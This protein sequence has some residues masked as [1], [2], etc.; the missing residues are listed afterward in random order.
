ME[1][2]SRV[3]M[4][5]AMKVHEVILWARA[6]KM[7]WLEA[8]AVLKIRPRTLRRWK[9]KMDRH[10]LQSLVDRRCRIPSL[11][12]VA[13]TTIDEILRLYRERYSGFNVRHFHEV[14]RRDHG[15]E[16]S[17]T[18][19]KR[20][21]QG[22]GLVRKQRARGTHRMRRERQACLGAM[23][24]LDGSR[25][26]WLASQPGQWQT[27]IC[28][29]D[30]ATGR[31]LHARLWPSES[32]LAVMSALAAVFREHGLPQRLY[33][34]R[35][36]W[37]AH[38]PRRG[39][40][41]DPQMRTQVQRALDELGIEHIRAYSPQ[42]R[43]RSER[44]NRTLQGRVVNELRVRGITTLEHANRF[45]MDYRRE[46]D[47]RFARPAADPASGFVALGAVDLDHYLC[48][49]ATR[50]VRPDNTVVLG[51]RLLQIP[52]QAGRRSCQGMRV[53]VRVH[54]AGHITVDAGPRRLAEYDGAGS[55]RRRECPVVHAHDRRSRAIL[56]SRSRRVRPRK[57]AAPAKRPDHLSKSSGHITC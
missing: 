8:A 34:D 19:V 21:L 24:H 33:T 39:G 10:G 9:W 27:M 20:V 44:A 56:R 37:A 3:A 29:V 50:T 6:K 40:K 25:H 30:D 45:L 51:K 49:R 48:V 55:L 53:V 36:S 18:F 31:L 7:T 54:L 14:V 42:A 4:E 52:K 38:T 13:G 15:V 23:L 1:A 28:V 17:Y 12:R 5:R 43:G 11:R 35:A 26:Q 16:Q 46:Y 57:P 2:Y 32:R 47:Q 41:A 22:A